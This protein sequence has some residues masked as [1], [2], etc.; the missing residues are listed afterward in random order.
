MLRIKLRKLLS[1]VFG[2]TQ[3]I[4]KH[5]KI[6]QWYK[7]TRG[8]SYQGA[9]TN[10]LFSVK[11]VYSGLNWITIKKKHLAH[12]VVSDESLLT[13]ALA[14]TT[15]RDAYACGMSLLF[16]FVNV[17]FALL[18]KEVKNLF[19]KVFLR[20]VLIATKLTTWKWC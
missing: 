13:R 16:T 9:S 5:T 8:V 14:G 19:S 3:C 17:T 20:T 18:I 1:N 2:V 10:Y 4:A 6:P 11:A 15:S 12:Y 7:P